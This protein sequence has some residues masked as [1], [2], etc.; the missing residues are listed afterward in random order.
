MQSDYKK[1]RH[2]KMTHLEILRKAIDKFGEEN[3]INM[4]KEE[5]LE[6][7]LAIVKDQRNTDEKSMENLIDEIADVTI[8]MEQTKML[9]PANLIQERIDY[10]MKRLKFRIENGK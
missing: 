10:K 8:M 1:I 5:C 6:L 3:Q 9:F 2:R 4:I 7:A